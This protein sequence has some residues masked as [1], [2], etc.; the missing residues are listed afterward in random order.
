MK[1]LISI[2][3]AFA[4][5]AAL[6]VT[7]AFAAPGDYYKTQPLNIDIK[8]VEGQALPTL[9]DTV[10]FTTTDEGA[11]PIETKNLTAANF[12]KVSED[13]ADTAKD[14]YNYNVAN[15]VPAASAFGH[16]GVYTYTINQALTVTETVNAGAEKVLDAD[17]ATYTMKVYVVDNNGVLEIQSVTLYKDGAKVNT[18]EGT[19]PQAP[20]GY[21]NEYFEKLPE[22]DDSSANDDYIVEKQV[23]DGQ[24]D[25]TKTFNMEGTLNLAG[26]EGQSVTAFIRDKTGAKTNRPVT[27]DAATGAFSAAIA[28]NEQIVLKGLPIGTTYTADENDPS[29]GNNVGQYVADVDNGTGTFAAKGTKTTVTNTINE[30]TPAGILIS[31]LPYIALALVAIGGLVAYVVVRRRNADEA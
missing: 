11:A 23:S 22:G 21:E 30:E 26:L 7:A 1:K 4:M 29:E 14:T 2:L 27:F 20:I 19:D 17:D 5:M 15:V 6:A 16:A 28:D 31:N 24:G 10:T 8:V 3:V 25:K 12:N 13:P 9:T 18:T